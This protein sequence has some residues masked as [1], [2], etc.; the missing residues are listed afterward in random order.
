VEIV[1]EEAPPWGKADCAAC[2]GEA[3]ASY[4][5][6]TKGSPCR[7]CAVD[8]RQKGRP[9]PD[10][11]DITVTA[12]GLASWK[13]KGTTQPTGTAPLPSSNAP[14]KQQTAAATFG[15]AGA[16]AA[17]QPAQEPEVPETPSNV[18]AAFQRAPAGLPEDPHPIPAPE[19]AAAE[20]LRETRITAATPLSDIVDAAMEEEKAV[21]RP[22]K[23]F[24]LMV[25]CAPT[26]V[27][28]KSPRRGSGNYVYRLD[29]VLRD[30]GKFLAEKSGV[31][32]F[33]DLDPWSRRDRLAAAAPKLA[34]H[35][36]NDIVVAEGVSG[37]NG[38]LKALVD[39]LRPYCGIEIV[40]VSA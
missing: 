24:I 28:A 15:A 9:L 1:V 19:P 20:P 34:E 37:A 18:P 14:V 10:Q 27:Q 32:S 3:S 8:A 39:S 40:P 11:F 12:E 5:F 13:P 29:E 6:N 31:V 17:P 26:R 21:G 30:L 4:G 2:G 23:S 38:D 22:A 35:F 16:P 36:A 25:N 7:I 33:Y